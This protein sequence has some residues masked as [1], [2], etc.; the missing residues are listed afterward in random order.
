MK[1]DYEWFQQIITTVTNQLTQFTLYLDIL[2]KEAFDLTENAPANRSDDIYTIYEMRIS[3]RELYVKFS[4]CIEKLKQQLAKD[5]IYLKKTPREEAR[6]EICLKKAEYW[7]GI[8][9]QLQSYQL[10]SYN[11]ETEFQIIRDR[12]QLIKPIDQP[13][14][15]NVLLPTYRINYNGQPVEQI[16]NN[17]VNKTYSDFAKKQLAIYQQLQTENNAN[18]V[19]LISDK[20]AN[21]VTDKINNTLVATIESV[22]SKYPSVTAA[23]LSGQITSIKDAYQ[24]IQEELD[25]VSNDFVNNK[26]S[27]ILNDFDLGSELEFEYDEEVPTSIEP[28]NNLNNYEYNRLIDE[29]MSL[30]NDILS[31]ASLQKNLDIL[32]ESVTKQLDRLRDDITAIRSQQENI[33]DV[34]R[35]QN[36]FLLESNTRINN[37]VKALSDQ[38]ANTITAIRQVATD[39]TKAINSINL[40]TALNEYRKQTQADID[41][42]NENLNRIIDLVDRQARNSQ[43]NED[44]LADY[45]KEL[46]IIGSSFSRIQ[47]TLI[48]DLT[49]LIRTNVND[50][51]NGLDTRLTSYVEQITLQLVQYSTQTTGDLKQE[52]ETYLQ[53]ISKTLDNKI[54]TDKL[55]KIA[56]D[57]EDINETLRSNS[58]DINRAF[59]DLNRLSGIVR[60]RRDDADFPLNISGKRRKIDFEE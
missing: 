8:L 52:L 42:L 13:I 5:D 54:P 15:S 1:T 49:N 58:N 36:K 50:L 18:V 51:F 29:I 33:D 55:N 45:V 43:K 46:E 32:N 23:E 60:K 44:K 17:A 38:E 14:K 22:V 35:S 39:T 25:I 31:N 21:Q 10:C 28:A 12:I 2:L 53:Q 20:V 27:P 26:K 30:K 4:K 24:S 16:I 41:T 40:N 9:D 7:Y 6:F 37:T 59:S 19:S 3:F 57:I 48:D 34:V 47:D 11:V 56:T